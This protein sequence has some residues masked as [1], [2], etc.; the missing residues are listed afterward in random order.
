MEQQLIKSNNSFKITIPEKVE[1]KI[2]FLCNKI[3]NTEWSGVLF[4]TVEGSFNTKDLNVICK[5]I[6]LMNI[7]NT[8]YTEFNNTPDIANYMAEH[9]ELLDC[10]NGLIHSHH[11]M[12]AFFSS[13]DLNTLKEEG[14]ERLHFVS[15]IVNNDGKYVAAITC[16]VHET[17]HITTK[18]NYN[19]FNDISVGGNDNQTIETDTIVYHN[20]DII[21]DTNNEFNEL[22]NRIKVLSK[23]YV[24]TTS[25]KN[26]IENS[27]K[28]G[29]FKFDNYYTDYDS[30]DNIGYIDI[31]DN[32]IK[33]ALLQIITGSIIISN[34]SRIDPKKWAN[35]MVAL[36][37]NKF[38]SISSYKV[39]IESHI[40]FILNEFIPS[41]YSNVADS[42]TISLATALY[43]EISSFPTNKYINI[44]LEILKTWM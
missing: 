34:A 23:P 32:T 18:F 2:R 15:L 26:N 1:S 29:E 9:P 27:I 5:D 22:D 38:D 31:E 36:F 12:Q 11:Q 16:K 37:D 24:N 33:T 17:K 13:T 28:Q 20:L 14:E 43:D 6:Y 42:Y 41:K 44:I 21:K 4:Y 10:Y 40:E 3:H 39:W 19:T 7:G 35:Q 30:Y 8:G 25:I